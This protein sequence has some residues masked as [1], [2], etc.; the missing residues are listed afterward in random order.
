MREV[1]FF[2]PT[3]VG[4]AV[5]LLTEHGNKISIVAGGTDLVPKINY[6]ELKPELL[7]YIGGMGLNYIKEEAGKLVIGAAT[8]TASLAVSELLAEKAAALYQAANASGSVA[9]R[10]TATIGGN[11]A[12][13][14]PAA[15]LATPLLVMDAE[16][17]LQGPDGERT[18]PLKEFFTAPHETVL[19]PDEL[20]TQFSMPVPK[21][22]TVFM[23]MGRRKA[24]TLSIANVA[25]RLAMEGNK[26]QEARIALG[27]VAPTPLCCPKAMD[28]LPGQVVDE[29]LLDKVA[30]AAADESKPI[31]D[32]RASAWHRKR[33]LVPLVKR[34]LAQAAGFEEAQE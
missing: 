27:S 4:E 7:M 21:G 16:V 29:A 1:D 22:K 5:K 2:A 12:N 24:F 18:V 19:Q 17:H 23:K 33:I 11:I 34:A 32:Q 26:C 8:T 15:D 6:Y 9:V 25:V 20:I 31:D 14:S 30:A 28:M 10:T 13:A 3:D